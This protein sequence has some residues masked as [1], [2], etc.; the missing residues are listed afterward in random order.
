L[1]AGACRAAAAAGRNY[2]IS[3][4]DVPYVL[5]KALVPAVRGVVWS[6]AHGRPPG[7]LLGRSVQIVYARGLHVGRG[8]SIGSWS[9]VE[10]CARDGV[11]LA[12]GTTIREHAW[13]QCRSGLHERGESLRVGESVYIGPH[14]VLGVGGPITIGARVQAGAGLM[15][16]AESHVAGEN[17]RFT[18][19]D[20]SRRGITI[21]DDVWIGNGVQILDGVAVGEGAVIGAGAVVTRDVAAFTTVAGVPARPIAPARSPAGGSSAG[22]PAAN[23]TFGVAGTVE[24][25]GT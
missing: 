14:A 12:D 16:A 25:A 21:G 19:G 24:V 8:V 9:Y 23:G 11:W 3:A 15:L 2:D 4:D 1:A 7:L 18:G 22:S 13:V 5:S 10:A 20:V 6:L 17:G